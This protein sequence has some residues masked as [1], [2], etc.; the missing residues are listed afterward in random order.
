MGSQQSIKHSKTEKLYDL[1]FTYHN[2]SADGDG[3]ATVRVWNDV[4]VPNRQKRDGYHPHG[5]ENVR[6]PDVVITVPN[7]TT[8]YYSGQIVCLSVCLSSTSGAFPA[9]RT[10]ALIPMLASTGPDDVTPIPSPAH[11]RPFD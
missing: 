2:S 9:A 8:S 10:R 6:V 11:P 7:N 3:A 4:A 5:V 1:R